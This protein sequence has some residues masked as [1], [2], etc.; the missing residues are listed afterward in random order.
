MFLDDL[1]QSDARV[2]VLVVGLLEC[3]SGRSPSLRGRSPN[4]SL[5]SRRTRPSA[6]PSANAPCNSPANGSRRLGLRP[7]RIACQIARPTSQ[8]FV[9][10]RFTSGSGQ[11]PNLQTRAANVSC[12]SPANGSDFG[13]APSSIR[14]Q[15]RQGFVDDFGPRHWSMSG[16]VFVDLSRVRGHNS[17]PLLHDFAKFG[18]NLRTIGLVLLTLGKTLLAKLPQALR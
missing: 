10:S 4:G 18:H 7:D 13:S 1:V 14:Q 17:L 3:G 16:D 11:S 5:P 2:V 12:N 8:R 9:R 6:N 15:L